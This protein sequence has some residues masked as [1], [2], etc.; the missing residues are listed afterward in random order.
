ME[1]EIEEKA[2]L[3]TLSWEHSFWDID[4]DKLLHVAAGLKGNS[5]FEFYGYSDDETVDLVYEQIV[6][7]TAPDLEPSERESYETSLSDGNKMFTIVMDGVHYLVMYRN[8]TVIYAY[9]SNSLD[10]INEILA[11]IG[12]L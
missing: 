1:E 12:Y 10:E 11:D 9:S 3:F 4:E 7:Q 2:L 5:K 6:Y 8:D